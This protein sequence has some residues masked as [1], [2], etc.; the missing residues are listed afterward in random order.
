MNISVLSAVRS[1]AQNGMKYL[2]GCT[3]EESALFTVPIA[4][5]RAFVKKMNKNNTLGCKKTQPSFVL[6]NAF[7]KYF[8]KILYYIKYLQKNCLQ[9]DKKVVQ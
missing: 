9:I 3:V 8:N 5:G 6:F 7:L 1:S 4:V 2:L